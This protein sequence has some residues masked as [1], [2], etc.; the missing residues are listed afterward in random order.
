ML[1]TLWDL[2]SLGT[3]HIT[4][5]LGA[6]CA[7]PSTSTSL[8]YGALRNTGMS[9]NTL[10]SYGND[11]EKPSR[12]HRSSSQLRLRDK[13]SAMKERLMPFCW[14]QAIW[15]WL[16]PMPTRGKGKWT[17]WSSMPGHWGNPFVPHGEWVDRM[18]MSSPPK[19]TF[20]H[21]SCE[22]HSP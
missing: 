17:I 18:I 22:G 3:V 21:C 20:P 9:T 15:S 7:Y 5:C 2:P 6:D 4:W 13:S 14:S 10:P 11:C 16:K 19:P 8:W 1:T 12:K